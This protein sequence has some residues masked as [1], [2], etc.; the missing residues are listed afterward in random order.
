MSSTTRG[1]RQSRPDRLRPGALDR[2]VVNRA[3]PRSHLRSG[4]EALRQRACAPRPAAGEGVLEHRCGPRPMH[5]VIIT[6]CQCVGAKRLWPERRVAVH[7]HPHRAGAGRIGSGGQ[8]LG[9]A[10]WLAGATT[11]VAQARLCRLRCF[12]LRVDPKGR[13]GAQEAGRLGRKLESLPQPA[14]YTDHICLI[15]AALCSPV[16]SPGMRLGGFLRGL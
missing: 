16:Q 7:R 3:Q 14:A 5:A 4:N 13:L 9:G 2:L 15:D 1:P 12:G 11:A 8:C 10:V 6:V